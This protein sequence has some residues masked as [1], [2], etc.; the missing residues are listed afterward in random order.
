DRAC[1][2]E[3]VL[4]LRLGRRVP[5][6]HRLDV[7]GLDRHAV[8]MAQEVLQQDLHREREPGDVEA[9]AQPGQAGVGVGLAV[10]LERGAG[11]EGIGHGGLLWLAGVRSV[12]SL[13]R[14]A[15]RPD[16]AAGGGVGPKYAGWS[17]DD[18]VCIMFP[19]RFIHGARRWKPPW[20]SGARSPCPRPCATP[21]A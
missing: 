7:P 6:R 15:S 21:W 19:Y 13:R 12:P 11:G 18:K 9:L 8:L 4:G 2:H 1:G 20:P 16:Y 3:G 14:F 10:D 5:V 17:M